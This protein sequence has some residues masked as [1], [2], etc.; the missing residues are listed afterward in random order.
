MSKLPLII[1]I[2]LAGFF[3]LRLNLIE[4]GN[5]PKDIPSV[6]IGKPVPEFNL[7]PLLKNKGL[8]TAGLKGKVTIVNFFASWCIDCLAE[9]RYLAGL[10]G[11]GAALVGV[12]YKDADKEGQAWLKKNGNPYNTVVADHDGRTAIDFG[13]Y[14]V[15]ET[16]LIDKHGIIRYKQTGPVTPDI[17]AEKLLPLIKELNK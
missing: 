6:M 13:V 14:G 9:H 16:Y 5:M 8:T 12:D 15:P 2:A 1:F 4:H 11:K 17:I 10:S 7:P 3:V